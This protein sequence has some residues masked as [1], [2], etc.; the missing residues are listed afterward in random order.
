MTILSFI[1]FNESFNFDFQ[2]FKLIKRKEIHYCLLA[3]VVAGMSV[4]G[5]KNLQHQHNIFGDFLK[6]YYNVVY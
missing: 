3:I 6:F 5:V 4:V 2:Y 1:L